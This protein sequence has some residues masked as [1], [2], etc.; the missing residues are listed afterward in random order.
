M[1]FWILPPLKPL[2]LR[3]LV[4]PQPHNSG[5]SWAFSKSLPF[6]EVVLPLKEEEAQ[7]SPLFPLPPRHSPSLGQCWSTPSAWALVWLSDLKEVATPLWGGWNLTGGVRGLEAASESL[8]CGAP[9]LCSTPAA[10]L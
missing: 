6:P 10:Q 8:E 9:P 3:V 2:S 7:S 5:Y 1:G 4:S